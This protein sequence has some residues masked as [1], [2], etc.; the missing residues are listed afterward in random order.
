MFEK[1]IDENGIENGMYIGV[2]I[3]LK[4]ADA[5]TSLLADVRKMQSKSS[6]P[7]NRV[8]HWK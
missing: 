3:C 6:S 7:K 4:T 8:I 1:T 2:G 5:D